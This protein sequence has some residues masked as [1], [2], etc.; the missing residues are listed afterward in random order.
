MKVGNDECRICHS[1]HPNTFICQS[2]GFTIKAP[3]RN[4]TFIIPKSKRFTYTPKPDI[5]TYELA[6]IVPVMIVCHS[7]LSL[8]LESLIPAGCERH[9]TEIVE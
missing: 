8:N 9:F 7:N 6:Q 4:S 2:D 3:E 5:T 1:Y